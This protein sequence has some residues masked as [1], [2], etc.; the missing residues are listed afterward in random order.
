VTVKVDGAIAAKPSD[1]EMAIATIHIGQLGADASSWLNDLQQRTSTGVPTLLARPL[2]SLL[3]FAYDVPASSVLDSDLPL[4]TAESARIVGADGSLVVGGGLDWLAGTFAVIQGF[5][6]AAVP[7]GRA[8]NVLIVVPDFRAHWIGDALARVVGADKLAPLFARAL[9]VNV[10][11]LDAR[12]PARRNSPRSIG[13]GQGV[14]VL[15][16]LSGGAN[17]AVARFAVRHA[18]DKIGVNVRIAAE[19]RSTAAAGTG[20]AAATPT[21]GAIASAAF[22]VRAVD[23]AVPVLGRGSPRMTAAIADVEAAVRLLA[24][25]AENFEEHRLLL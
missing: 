6:G 12:A 16:E 10:Q 5:L 15:A 14:A 8:A 25:I 1:S 22:G 24:E 4:V 13:I 3:S 19:K 23:V 11:S 18:A 9:F 7:R 17:D 2:A 20:V 21:V